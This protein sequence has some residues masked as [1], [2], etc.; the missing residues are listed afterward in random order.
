[1]IISSADVRYFD[2]GLTAVVLALP[3]MLVCCFWVHVFGSSIFPKTMRIAIAFGLSSP[4]IVSVWNTLGTH[5][6]MLSMGAL[7]FKEALLGLLL[8]I[9]LCCP[10]WAMEAVGA[11][12]DQQRGANMAQIN[13]PFA[14]QDLSQIGAVLRLA[15]I[16]FLV[17]TG[18]LIPMYELIMFSYEAWP[19]VQLVPDLTDFTVQDISGKFGHFL[20]LVVLYSAPMMMMVALIDLGFA[21]VGIFAP[22]LPTYFAA[23]PVKSIAG[24]FI[25][26]LYVPLLLNHGGKY[27]EREVK[28]L[29]S[30]LQ[31]VVD[32]QK[33]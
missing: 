9:V 21:L 8:G 13:T 32:K 28:Y 16:A 10:F 25:L 33:R 31:T 17:S 18:G 24:M 23:M 5:P 27:F 2:D 14:A 6:T 22:S 4:V 1:M 30:A 20:A 3:R 11:V 29:E 19:V 12:F 26:G 15:F 7:V